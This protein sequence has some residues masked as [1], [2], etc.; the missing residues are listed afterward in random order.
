MKEKTNQN[1]P[2]GD[3]TIKLTVYLY[4][5]D[6]K[7]LE[8]NK[9]VALNEGT[10]RMNINRSRGIRGQTDFQFDGLIQIEDKIKEALKSAGVILVDKKGKQKVIVDY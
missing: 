9:K 6:L 7:E 4:T 5:N 3:K 2:H 10:V 1:I 8:N